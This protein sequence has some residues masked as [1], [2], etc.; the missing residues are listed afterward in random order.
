MNKKVK[1]LIILVSVVVF[2]VLGLFFFLKYSLKK[3]S[4]KIIPEIT[5]EEKIDKII[6]DYTGHVRGVHSFYVLDENSL[7]NLVH[8]VRKGSYYEISCK[9]GPSYSS[10]NLDKFYPK[11][12]VSMGQVKNCTLDVA[13]AID[14]AIRLVEKDCRVPLEIGPISPSLDDYYLVTLAIEEQEVTQEWID[15]TKEKECFE[16][17]KELKGETI[18]LGF[19]TGIIDLNKNI[20]IY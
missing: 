4:I 18:A 8:I 2:A 19:L 14:E 9:F 11:E 12:V 16:P 13:R 10:A 6:F 15:R 1:I 3:T 5:G 17:L 7:V 20:L